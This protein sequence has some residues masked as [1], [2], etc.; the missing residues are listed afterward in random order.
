MASS[1]DL[2][3]KGLMFILSSPSGAGKTTISRKLLAAESNLDMS[4]SV[5]T[6]PMRPG[7]VEGKDYH[8]VSAERFK[9]MVA[10]D[11]FLEW[12]EVFGNCYGTPRAHIAEGLAQGQD[13]LF[14]VDWQGAQQ[15]SQRAGKD[16][17]SVFLLP[18]S[19]E[20]LEHRLRSRGTDS[21][22]VIRDRMDRARAEISHWDG[23]DYV[24][25]NDDIEAC[26][27]KVKTILAAERLRR[28]RRKG[29][30]E[31]VRG[32]MQGS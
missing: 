24:V 32:L 13:Y 31:F 29:L 22:A 25:V 23:Y 14:D 12:A 15:L 4:V 8:F 30:V 5:T 1:K 11:A 6:R 28:E 2:A 26:F 21:D 18:P 9:E 16:V 20:E 27:V 19:I 10:E 3:R 17:V 7:E